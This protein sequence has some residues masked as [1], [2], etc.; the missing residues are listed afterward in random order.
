MGNLGLGSIMG[1]LEFVASPEL[2]QNAREEE[3]GGA[4]YSMQFHCVA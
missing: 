3:R 2:K 1:L 4:I